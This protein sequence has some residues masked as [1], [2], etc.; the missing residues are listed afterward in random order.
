MCN[1]I[2]SHTVRH[3]DFDF[4]SA[5]IDIPPSNSSTEAVGFQVG[6]INDAVTEERDEM[7]TAVLSSMLPSI[8]RVNRNAQLTTVTIQDDDSKLFL[9]LHACDIG[10]T[11]SV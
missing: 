9:T 6:I 3:I 2:H 1:A 4:V 5:E 10:S 8:V 7:F 11:P